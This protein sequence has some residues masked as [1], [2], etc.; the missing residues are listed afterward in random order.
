MDREELFPNW[1]GV[2]GLQ[3]ILRVE[4]KGLGKRSGRPGW[5]D[6]LRS[7]GREAPLPDSKRKSTQ[8]PE[9]NVQLG[10]P[11]SEVSAELGPGAGFQ[12]GAQNLPLG[13]CL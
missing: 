3:L 9:L 10:T 8:R 1:A 2:P 12:G 4:T 7:T 6:S 5:A 13:R 11:K